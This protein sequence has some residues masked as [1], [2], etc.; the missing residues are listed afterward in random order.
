MAV[1]LTVDTL[2]GGTRVVHIA[3]RLDAEATADFEA[4]LLPLAE[5]AGVSRIVLEGSGLVYVAS[6]GL[7]VLV[8]AVKGMTPRKAKLLAAAMPETV[9]SVLKMTGFLSFVDL[10]KTVD[11][12]LA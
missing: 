2:E 1:T 4:A 10:R 11:E 5:D 12:C 9:V 3:G 6:A 7:R 8:K